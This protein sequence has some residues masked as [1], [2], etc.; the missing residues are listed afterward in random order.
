MSDKKAT[1]GADRAVLIH[2]GERWLLYPAG[3][4]A[5]VASEPGSGSA[6]PQGVQ[7]ALHHL[8]VTRVRLLLA[9]EVCRPDIVLPPR[10]SYDEVSAL[11]TQEVGDLSGD[12]ASAF[13]CAGAPLLWPGA[14]KSA[15]LAGVFATERIAAL[16]ETLASIGI[17]FD[18]VASLALACMAVG[19]EK[20]SKSSAM[21]IVGLGSAL[22]VP[23]AKAKPPHDGPQPFSGGTRH[24]AADAEGWTARF[25]RH[26]RFFDRDQPL[27]VLVQSP[28]DPGIET[29]LRQS[30]GFSDVRLA[31][32][33]Q[34][35]A[36]AARLTLASKCN[37][38]DSR[39]PVANPY[40]PRKR[41]SH[42]WIV[43]PSLLIL[44]V[45]FAAKACLEHRYTQ[46]TA[47]LQAQIAQL[48]P[49]EQRIQS[50]ERAMK[51]AK[52]AFDSDAAARHRMAECRRPLA[53]A[54]QVAYFFCRYSGSTV[55]LH[56]LKEQN[57]VVRVK[58]IYSDPEDGLRLNGH[59]TAFAKRTG[60]R[61]LK[62]TTGIEKDEEGM[63]ASQ[64][65]ILLDYSNMT[66]G[67][68]VQ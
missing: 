28:S 22:A 27:T 40:E 5:P 33:G 47:N 19:L 17:D 63:P 58:G 54:V 7:E 62:N 30:C 66:M 24:L 46:R 10:I 3:S 45:P 25:R 67:G 14:T 42:A 59:L 52:Q 15:L 37:R 44:A 61:I 43:V 39:L 53:A 57:G 68:G 8:A 4:A 2:D 32:R 18:G 38:I 56:E 50:A 36:E 21:L 16:K 6:L 20:M 1:K 13:V 35:F 55:L 12:D 26:I 23:L 60:L 48:E 41:F 64:F 34:L 65:E 9:G 49:T 11:V 51:R 29:V 31:D